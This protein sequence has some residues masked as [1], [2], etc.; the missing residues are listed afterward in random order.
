MVVDLDLQE[1]SE[2]SDAYVLLISAWLLGCRVPAN[3]MLPV[4][5]AV[6]GCKR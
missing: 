4:L 2:P 6:H 3:V 1:E 5:V